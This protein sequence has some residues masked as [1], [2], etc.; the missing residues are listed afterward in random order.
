MTEGGIRSG[1]T[2]ENL[3]SSAPPFTLNKPV[4]FVGF[5]GA[6]KTAT[7]RKIARLTG[8]P[9]LD[10]DVFIERRY[11]MRPRDIIVHYG[12]AA[13]RAIESEV[14]ITLAYDEPRFI[15]CGGG[16]VLDARNREILRSQGYVVYLKV[17][18]EVAASRISDMA[19]RP[20]FGDMNEA[21][22]LIRERQPL[23]EEVAHF[24]VNTTAHGA[25]G[26]AYDILKE[27]I[28]CGVLQEQ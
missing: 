20:L 2:T 11:D 23:Y 5:M 25:G 24:A 3:R 22:R 17:S 28:S 8:V 12:E 16:V 6:G 9:S 18:A 15:S 4:F 27:L 21:R 19:T 10:M 1:T 7:S 14:L 13:F 26:T